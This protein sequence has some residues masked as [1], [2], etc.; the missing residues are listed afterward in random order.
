MKRSSTSLIIMK[1]QI[2]TTMRYQFTP[3]RVVLSKVK[4]IS[5]GEDVEKRQLLYTISG[6]VNWYSFY[7]KWYG[8]SSK[9]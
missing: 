9:Y 6:N 1:M 4:E 5:V 3:V 2:K 8:G 7:G